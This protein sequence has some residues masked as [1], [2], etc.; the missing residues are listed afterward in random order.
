MVLA[1]PPLTVRAPPPPVPPVPPALG[2]RAAVSTPRICLIIGCGGRAALLRGGQALGVRPCCLRA[3]PQAQGF[4]HQRLLAGPD[5]IRLRPRLCAYVPPNPPR[6][7]S[8]PPVRVLLRL[9][10]ANAALHAR[11]DVV[12]PVLVLLHVLPAE[13][14]PPPSRTPHPPRPISHPPA[15][16]AELRARR[17]LL[18]RRGPL[19]ALASAGRRLPP[20]PHP[21][22]PLCLLPTQALGGPRAGP[23][24]TGARRG[25]SARTGGVK[26]AVDTRVRLYLDLIHVAF[27]I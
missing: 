11:P 26:C 1:A 16:V 19:P 6:T 10:A 21:P 27:Y 12:L 7:T 13:L 3:R 17:R 18:A 8:R 5:G 20:R 25:A 4:V 15:P 2:R 23:G 22:H 9:P 14:V 24:G